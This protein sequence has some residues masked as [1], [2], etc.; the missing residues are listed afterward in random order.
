[1][2]FIAGESLQGFGVGAPDDLPDALDD[3]LGALRDGE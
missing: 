3:W 1:M 2:E